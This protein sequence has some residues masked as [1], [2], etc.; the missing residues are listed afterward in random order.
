MKWTFLLTLFVIFLA[1]EPIN[2]IFIFHNHQPWYLDFSKNELALP[3]VR[4]HAV[5]N[6]LKVPLLINQSGV[7]VVFTLSGSLIEQLNWYSNGTYT[8]ARFR[9][10]KRPNSF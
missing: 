9:I 4:M 8:D 3:W 1:A 2:I 10:S 6:Y 5:G 7:S